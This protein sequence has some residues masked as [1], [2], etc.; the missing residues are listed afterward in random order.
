MADRSQR[1]AK[2]EQMLVLTGASAF[3]MPREWRSVGGCRRWS[4]SFVA[5][6]R[7]ALVASV[8]VAAILALL[9]QDRPAAA[10][11]FMAGA[12]V[13]VPAGTTIH[14][15][16]Y[17]AGGKVSVLGTVH[18]DLVGEAALLN[19]VGDI[20][21]SVTVAAGRAEIRGRIAHA[22][23]ALG[24]VIAIYGR[25]DGDVVAAGGAVTLVEGAAVGGD[26]VAA[27]GMVTVVNS[28]TV[29]GNVRGVAANM[30]IE[31]HIGGNIRVTVDHLQL[32]DGAT[33]QREL[34]YRSD[35][36]AT[37]APGAVVAGTTRRESL[38][39]GVPGGQVIFWERAAIPR[40]L[41][42][43]GVGV[44]ILLLLPGHAIAVANGVRGAPSLALLVGIGATV[45]VPI[46]LALLTITIVG[47]PLALV[48][49]T[50][51]LGGTYLSQVF[52]GLALGRI[53]FRLGQADV[54]R[55]PNLVAMCGGIVALTG[56]RLLPFP[57]L[58][59]LIAA[60][61]A[62]LGLGALALAALDCTCFRTNALLARSDSPVRP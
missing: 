38:A 34:H 26:V 53:V 22:V 28:A 17:I 37:I 52:V 41:L 16:L 1:C 51:Y 19:V 9:G 10:A 46:T 60:V 18:G 6:P 8:L 54:R 35:N 50:L 47:I 21:G 31:G 2:V 57:H 13:Q 15:D 33:I 55:G 48:G 58:D 30:N 23:R 39:G 44:A 56:I 61:V 12:S 49:T 24:G 29:D 27:G 36:S 62:V 5:A 43:L 45:F 42:L 11:Q 25:V 3:A 32:T 14:G 20:D 4:N 40:A 59:L 7:T